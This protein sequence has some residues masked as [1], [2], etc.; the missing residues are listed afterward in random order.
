MISSRTLRPLAL[1]TCL[2]LGLSLM[3]ATAHAWFWRSKPTDEAQTRESQ[4]QSQNQNESRTQNQRGNQSQNRNNQNR[5][6]RT[7]FAQTCEITQISDGDSFQARCTQGNTR[8]LSMQKVRLRAIDAPELQQRHG[9]AARQ[10]LVRLCHNARF[11]V[12]AQTEL[13]RFGR[14]LIN[15]EC[16]GVDV[17][18]RMVSSGMAWVYHHEA[19][20]HPKLV[21]LQKQAQRSGLGLWGDA[22]PVAPWEWRRQNPR[23]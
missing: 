11:D 15:I 20:N 13:D 5:N 4:S 16:N 2:S 10:A 17:A 18:E 21:N 22:D 23:Q 12:P 14:L 9:Q 19:K 3:P 8:R 1:A 6:E 7:R